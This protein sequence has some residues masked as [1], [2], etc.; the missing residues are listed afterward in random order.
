MVE[1]HELRDGLTV[2]FVGRCDMPDKYQCLSFERLSLANFDF[3]PFVQSYRW[4]VLQDDDEELVSCG[5]IEYWQTHPRFV[6]FTDDNKKFVHF[7]YCDPDH[8]TA[9]SLRSSHRA[10]TLE[11]SIP[12]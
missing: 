10:Q 6:V 3:C 4:I 8:E 2:I 11:V 9:T 5:G 1:L 7:G 12:G